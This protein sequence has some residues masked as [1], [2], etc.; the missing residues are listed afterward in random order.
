MAALIN[1]ARAALKN[2]EDYN[3]RANIMWASSFALCGMLNNGKKT[4]WAS[5]CIEHPLS[6][7]F[8]IAHGAGLAVVH[9]VYLEYT[10]KLSPDRFARFAERVWNVDP[11]GKTQEEVALEG[12]R[13]VREFFNEL[14][15]PSTLTELGV[16]EADFDRL[17]DLT[18]LSCYNYKPLER[19]DVRAILTKAL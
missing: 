5:H 11:T 19:K 18:D 12:V 2:P 6:A 3:A 17:I 13:K 7:L 10:Y 1:A 16:T 4:D 8:D 9:P 14:G 15:A